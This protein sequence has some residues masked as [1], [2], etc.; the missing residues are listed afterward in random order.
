[1]AVCLAE[2]GIGWVWRIHGMSQIR[3]RKIFRKSLIV[4]VQQIAHMHTLL[5]VLRV[6]LRVQCSKNWFG[7]VHV[8]C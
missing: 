4:C 2:E 8:V 7:Q 1:M 5:V 3:A 6:S